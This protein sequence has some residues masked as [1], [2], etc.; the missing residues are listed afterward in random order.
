MG[1]IAEGL[2]NGDFDEET[3]EWIGPGDGYP[4]SL[5]REAREKREAKEKALKNIMMPTLS[6]VQ[7]KLIEAGYTITVMKNID[8]G[9][10]MRT[11]SGAIVNVYTSGKVI[12]QGKPDEKLK[13]LIK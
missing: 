12:L 8:Y 11:L 7:K 1:E 6:A 4:R 3:G 9:I 13:Q 2:I 10:Q 5:Q